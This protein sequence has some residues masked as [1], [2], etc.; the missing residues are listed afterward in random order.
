MPRLT[1]T[2][3]PARS[4]DEFEIR[5]LMYN[6]NISAVYHAV[7]KH[8]GI[9]VALKL[10]KRAKLT[11]IERTQVCMHVCACVCVCG[12]KGMH[13]HYLKPVV[14]AAWSPSSP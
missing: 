9:T 4:V 12:E 13:G 3:R 2:L 1:A 14:A 8:S 6:G 5:R 10:Y 11:D 7:D